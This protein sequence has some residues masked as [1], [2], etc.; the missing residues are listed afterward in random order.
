MPLSAQ[1][2][3]D[4]LAPALEPSAHAWLQS[5]L[6]DGALLSNRLRLRTAFTQVARKLGR[7]AESPDA[8]PPLGPTQVD[9]ARLMLVC[10]ALERMPASEHV[11][12]LEEL[13]RTGEQREQQSILRTLF[14]LP[15]AARFLA[16]AVH[17]CRTNSIPVFGAI[18][19]HNPY[20]A[21]H[22]SELSFNQLVLKAIF[23]GVPVAQIVDLELRKNDELRRMLVEYASERRAASRPVPADVTYALALFE[24]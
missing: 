16:L 8:E 19:S 22:F 1:S 5:A 17:A 18:A 23:L 10:A 20:P 2:Q 7:A 9:R 13:Y 11:S 6:A 24:R 14:S 4:E 21:A 12:L 3:L 15:D